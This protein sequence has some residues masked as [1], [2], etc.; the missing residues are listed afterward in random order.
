M[1]RAAAI[2]DS[3]AKPRNLTNTAVLQAKPSD[4]PYKLTDSGGLYV[5]IRP[6]G[7]K[8]WRYRFRIAG[9]ETIYT[10][11]DFDKSNLDLLQARIKRDQL[12]QLVRRGK[13]P[14]SEDRA[15]KL[16]QRYENAQTFDALLDEWLATRDWGAA[17]R[18]NRVGQID[19]HVR[20]YLGPLPVKEITPMMVLEVLRRAEK[21]GTVSKASG[22][23]ARI[24]ETGGAGVARRLRQYIAG[25]MDLAVATERAD[26]NPAGSLRGG[27]T[28][29]KRTVHKTPLSSTQVG[30]LLR[31]V[32]GYL[33]HFLTPVAFR[34]LWWSVARPGEVVGAQW[35]E[36]D[37]EAATWTIPPE[38]M[39]MGEPHRI[40]LPRQAVEALRGLK[41]MTSGVG[42]VFPH[43]DQR[44]KP[45]T[46]DAL[47]KAVTRMQLGFE[48]SPHATRTTAS[49][50]L[51]EM[52]YRGDAIECQLA[53]KDK[54]DIRDSYNRTDYFDERREIMQSWADLLD[55]WK[56]GAKVLPIGQK[57]P[58]KTAA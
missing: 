3:P 12:R 33:G 17:T 23:G 38:R 4:K 35:S 54:N 6:S 10:L 36:I 47:A 8:I 9:K 22:R 50:I 57:T 51:N 19:L 13:N 28:K 52:G 24:R 46:R 39:K 7:K 42:C 55:D 15:A 11:G 30:E 1:T 27:L 18:L 32:D 43:R 5:D 34:M 29:A 2:A 31:K 26:R 45:M 41:S 56:A 40:P 21:P 37:L 58:T 49:T 16:R 25:I 20:R 44:N 48:Y 14:T 53:H